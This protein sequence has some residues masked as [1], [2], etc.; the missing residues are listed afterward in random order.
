MVL[1][2]SFVKEDTKVIIETKFILSKWSTKSTETTYSKEITPML[3]R[4]TTPLAY[5]FISS[6]IYGIKK[7]LKAQSDPIYN[8]IL[9]D[10]QEREIVVEMLLFAG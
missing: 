2:S 4:I 9:K 5:S 6:T 1:V 8:I 3:W 7:E 10:K